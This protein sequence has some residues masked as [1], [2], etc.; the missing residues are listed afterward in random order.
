MAVECGGQ[1]WL[2]VGIGASDHNGIADE[3]EDEDFSVRLQSEF[4]GGASDGDVLPARWLVW[5][6]REKVRL[7]VYLWCLRTDGG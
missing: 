3:R 7:E 6:R 5:P 4:P 2:W 1:A